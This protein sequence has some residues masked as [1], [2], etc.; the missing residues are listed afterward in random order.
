MTQSN[1]NRFL[2]SLAALCVVFFFVSA[3]SFTPIRKRLF[4]R[5]QKPLT[6]V[7]LPELNVSQAETN[8]TAG[9][10]E[11]KR[12]LPYP[13]NEKTNTLQRLAVPGPRGK[14]VEVYLLGT[15]HVSRDSSRDVKLLLEH[16][17]PDC[18]FLELCYQR[19][20]C[21]VA[22]KPDNTT[23]KGEEE[24]K[25]SLWKQL[26]QPGNKSLY[27]IAANLLASMQQGYGTSL[28]V[29]V[30]GEFRVAHDYWEIQR[31]TNTRLHMILGDRP[32]S[33][34]LTRAWESMG[35][36]GKTKLIVSLF[37]ASLQKTDAKE[38][39][40]LIQSI[41]ND[42]SGDLLTKLTTELGYRFPTL[43]EVILHERNEF[44]ACKLIQSCRQ[45]VMQPSGNYTMVA[46]VGAGHV[47]GIRRLLTEG[48]Y[49]QGSEQILKQLIQTNKPMDA[50]QSRYL[51]QGVMEV[52]HEHLQEIA[53][54]M[55]SRSNSP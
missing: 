10:P 47:E 35:V 13:L 30:G 8:V 28:G 45:L 40:E 11:W 53:R 18:I 23:V 22:S 19:M 42:D 44:M 49:G 20:P 37:M 38:L 3:D 36:W 54:Q 1:N 4:G 52:N 41:L 7:V 50:E 26:R 5:R 14:I 15:A 6:L 32:I 17:N 29:E 31:R 33:L 48:N 9:V 46:I 39:E 55:N 24:K 12:N 21:L 2:S 34:T 51:V 16:V 27:G 43:V 25:T